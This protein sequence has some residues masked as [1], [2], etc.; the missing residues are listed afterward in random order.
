[1]SEQVANVR[2]D[3]EVSRLKYGREVQRLAA[4][5]ATLQARGIFVFGVPVFP[6]LDLLYVP[7]Q[8]LS[9][10][11][12]VKQGTTLF[13]P[14]GVVRVAEFP[15]LSARAFKVRFD[16]TDYDLRPPSV[17]LLDP[18]TDEILPY[19]MMFRALEFE[20]DRGT[21]VVLLGDHPN[22][23]RPFICL[24]GIREYHEHPQHSGDEWLLYRNEI[25]VF[26]IILSI[27]RVAV[28]LVRPVLVQQPQGV[29]IH[30]VAKEKH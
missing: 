20:K 12:S 22:T 26:S 17:L 6:T 8:P 9:I 25:S 19:E 4:D 11:V 5:A 18:W 30:W 14:Q 16:L 28:D 2:V 13:L 3:P 23:H 7:R 27:W 29:Q 21:H 15:S 24:R 10:P 1:V